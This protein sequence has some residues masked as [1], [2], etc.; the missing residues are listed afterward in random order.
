MNPK[1]LYLFSCIYENG[2]PSRFWRRSSQNLAAQRRWFKKRYAQCQ[3]TSVEVDWVDPMLKRMKE[4]GGE[5]W[6][7]LRAKAQWEHMSLTSVLM[8]Y[9]DLRG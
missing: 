9:P 1:T 2:R 4:R 8:E 3:L 7:R 6:E 5:P